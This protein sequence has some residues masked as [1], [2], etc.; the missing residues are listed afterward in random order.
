MPR[1]FI[2]LYIG[3]VCIGASAAVL[4]GYSPVLSTV[5]GWLFPATMFGAVML[6]L[7]IA[8]R[9]KDRLQVGRRVQVPA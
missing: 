8:R 6:P 9:L 7:T 2:A 4:M 1:L 3:L 5:A